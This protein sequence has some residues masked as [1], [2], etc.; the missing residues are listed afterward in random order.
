MKIESSNKLARLVDIDVYLDSSHSLNRSVL[1]KCYLCN[2]DAIICSRMKS[3]SQVELLSYINKLTSSY[4]RRY[5]K[6][7]YRRSI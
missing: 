6:K 1:R 4:L 7:I 2:K 3:H 5:I